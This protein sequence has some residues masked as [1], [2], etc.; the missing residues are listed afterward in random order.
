[1]RRIIARGETPFLHTRTNNYLAIELYE[2]L[3]F[4][5]RRYLDLAVLVRNPP[6]PASD[7]IRS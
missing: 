1:M 3:G 2:H 7:T 5:I 4:R 6:E